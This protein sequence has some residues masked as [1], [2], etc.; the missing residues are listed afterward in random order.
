MDARV[1][2]WE[3]IEFIDTNDD[4]KIGERDVI[5]NRVPLKDLTWSAVF[6][7]DRDGATFYTI[8]VTESH[9]WFTFVFVVSGDKYTVGS[10]TIPAGA[11]ITM[12]AAFPWQKSNSKLMLIFK[13][14][15]A[16]GFTVEAPNSA[17]PQDLV[18]YNSANVIIGNFQCD[19]EARV[20]AGGTIAVNIGLDG[21]TTTADQANNV[22][23]AG[24]RSYT[25]RA[26]V[27]TLGAPDRIVYDP[28]LSPTEFTPTAPPNAAVS[29]QPQYIFAVLAAALCA[30]L[31]LM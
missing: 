10:R 31:R 29:C 24:T 1:I 25:L 8:T 5:V 19:K 18:V 12:E 15:V 4:C 2:L 11:R 20:G 22:A 14:V 9:G 17:A 26:C 28:V 23:V 6:K 27:D 3:A 30:I 7:T 13:V 21:D 16:G